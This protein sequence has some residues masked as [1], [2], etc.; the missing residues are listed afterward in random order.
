MS[1]LEQDQALMQN[2]ILGSAIGYDDDGLVD[3]FFYGAYMDPDI[4]AVNGGKPRQQR[5]AMLPGYRLRLGDKATLLKSPTDSAVGCVYSL[6]PHEIRRLYAA[7]PDYHPI[8]DATVLLTSGFT[9]SVMFMIL[10]DA[11]AEHIR[12]VNYIHQMQQILRRLGFG[13]ED[14]NRIDHA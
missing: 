10:S 14:I 5:L 6:Y 12:N 2:T 7:H 1:G 4:L 13:E 8:A 3:V 11:P 9:A